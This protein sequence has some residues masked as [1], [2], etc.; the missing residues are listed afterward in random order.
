MFLAFMRIGTF[1]L[2][3]GLAMV[4]LIE[5]EFV[6]RQGWLDRDEMVEILAVS[7]SLPGVIAINSSLMVGYRVKGLPGALWAAAGMILPPFLIILLV[8]LFMTGLREFEPARKVF[9]GIRACMTGLLLV[10]AWRMGSRVIRHPV[11]VAAFV[12]SLAALALWD[13]SFMLVLGSLALGGMVVGP[14]LR[15]VGKHKP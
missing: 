2:G 7:Q 15:R 11:G 12:A 4:P 9:A 10:T 8:A 14:I 13:V 5:R 3:G 1:T 6:D